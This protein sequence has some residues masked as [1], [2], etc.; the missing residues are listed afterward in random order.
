MKTQAKFDSEVDNQTSQHTLTAYLCTELYQDHVL[1]GGGVPY[2]LHMLHDIIKW[3]HEFH[4]VMTGHSSWDRQD[5]HHGTS[6][7]IL[8]QR[9]HFA[10]TR[11]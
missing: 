9:G 5:A 4:E 11:Q 2:D 1:V 3:R 6:S 7:N 10:T 8:S